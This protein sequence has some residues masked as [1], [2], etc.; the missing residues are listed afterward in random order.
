MNGE[1][2]VWVD[3]FLATDL[4][5][6]SND[7]DDLDRPGWW[8][9]VGEFEG[10][11]QLARFGRVEQQPMPEGNW[12]FAGQWVSSCSRDQYMDDVERL[13]EAISRGEI[14]QTNLCRVL[15]AH[16]TEDLL[17]L[18]ALLQ[19]R[20]PAPHAAWMR[21]PDIEI[22]CASPERFLE[23]EGTTV[24]SSPIKG[25][26]R[27]AEEMTE[28][29]RAENVMIVDLVRHDLAQVCLPGSVTTPRL[30]GFEEHP[31]LV[32]LVS[33]VQGT[34]NPQASWSSLL[35]AT[36]P[37]G[38][39][40]GAPKLSALNFIAQLEAAPRGPYCGAIG[41]VDGERGRLAVGIRTF[42]RRA[43]SDLLHFGTGAG[44][45]WGSDPAAEWDETELKAARLMAL[46]NGRDR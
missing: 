27:T 30:L 5:E 33:D 43:T 38:S 1:P 23:R 17:G 16:C 29:D 11:W 25:T 18:A 28:K 12:D 4:I 20:H 34:L 36:F 26:A 13:R 21:L 40:T 37:P 24:L 31:G 32:H 2:T 19:A 42:W 22:V 44:I 41:W 46:A 3:G 10:S 8:A 9:V 45:T 7:L 6:L 15:S 35:R 39:V 14:Y